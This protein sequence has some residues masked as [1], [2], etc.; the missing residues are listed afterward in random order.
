MRSMNRVA[1][2][3]LLI[4][5]GVIHLVPLSGVLSGERISALYGLAVQDPNLEILLRHRAVLFGVLGG[6][7]V[8]AALRPTLQPIALLVGFVS[9]LSFLGLAWSVG[10]YNGALRSV[11]MADLLAAGCLTLAAVLRRFGSRHGAGAPDASPA[12]SA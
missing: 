12:S 5:V 2:A 3:A 6:F 10:G 8:Y 4:V 7:L 9:V 1:V 11:V